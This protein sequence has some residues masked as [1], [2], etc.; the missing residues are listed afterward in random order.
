M[1][2]TTLAGHPLHPQLVAFPRGMLS[3]GLVLDC[4]YLAT[5]D[6]AYAKAA[7]Y[8]TVGGFATGAAAALAGA[9]DYFAIPTRSHP[10]R[11][12]NVHALL[13]IGLMGAT[14]VN[15]MIRRG[16]RTP[17]G[18]LDTAL[19]AASGVAMAFSG[20]YGGDLVYKLGL[21]VKGVDPTVGA[22]ELAPAHD[23]KIDES[24]TRMGERMAPTEGT[25]EQGGQ[26]KAI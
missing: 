13:N 6:R 24:L 15:L 11:V 22:P 20:W 7:Y 9:G 19:S 10:K 18:P 26:R 1:P 14:A 2:R 3:L 8:S 21:R 12:A 23:R 17:S 16:K 5:G 4:M 25:S